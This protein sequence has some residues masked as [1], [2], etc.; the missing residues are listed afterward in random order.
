MKEGEGRGRW[1][2]VRE[3][4]EVKIR[5][6]TKWLVGS[7]YKLTLIHMCSSASLAL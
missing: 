2:K 7:E 1:E 3:G 6:E 5:I 4:K